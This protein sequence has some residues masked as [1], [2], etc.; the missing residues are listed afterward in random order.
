ML[1]VSV[2]QFAAE[3][4]TAALCVSAAVAILVLLASLALQL[5]LRPYPYAFQ[6]S[7]EAV[8]LLCSVVVILLGLAYAF[9]AVQSTAVEVALM[10]VLLG[11]LVLGAAY[12]AYKHAK[13][14]RLLGAPGRLPP[15]LTATRPAEGAVA[16]P[17]LWRRFS[18]RS[19]QGGS[20]RGSQATNGSVRSGS[21]RG[22][23]PSRGSLHS[24]E[25]VNELVSGTV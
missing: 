3:V 21:R 22:S 20:R 19:S 4:S 12:L 7:L 17:R 8:L 16:P 25:S 2:P 10:S 24:T 1:A 11:S 6:N 5:R 13:L 18:S 9:L 15:V 14:A 23:A